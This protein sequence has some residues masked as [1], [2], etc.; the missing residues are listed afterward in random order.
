MSKRRVIFDFGSTFFTVYS[1]GRVLL[2]K[3]CAIIMKKSL[4][5]SV[6]ST[7]WEA[8]SRQDE[9]SEEEFFMRPV[10]KGAVAHREGC[11][12]LIKSY[13]AEALGRFC[14]PSLCVLIGCGL[15]AE[16]RLQIEEA[17]VAAGYTDLFLMESLYGLLPTMERLSVKVGVII[18]GETAEVGIF[19]GGRLISGYSVS[20]GSATVNER[21]KDYVRENYKL[22]LS[23]EGAEELKLKA[24]TLYPNDMTRVTASGKDALTGKVKKFTLTAKELYADT[25]YVYS[26]ILKVADA[27][28]TAAPLEIV[29]AVAKTGVLFAGGGSFE[30]GLRDYASSA[31]QLPVIAGG[32]GLPSSGAEKLASNDDFRNSYLDLKRNSTYTRL[33]R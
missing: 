24:S 13:I 22:I 23:E 4:Q 3:P 33:R 27:A 12:L 32:E 20:I 14:R 8:L 29:R 11:V 25:A 5:L 6:A 10:R 21:I 26:R 31:L 18:G 16:Q 17:F 2:R 1:E 15:N 19:E 30:E 28:L 9:V 7:G